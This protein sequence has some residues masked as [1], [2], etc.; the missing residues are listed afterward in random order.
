MKYRY[1]GTEYATMDD[2]IQGCLT[3]GEDPN[4]NYEVK[5]HKGRWIDSGEILFNLIQI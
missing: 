3:S 5:D 4:Y 2:M 1:R